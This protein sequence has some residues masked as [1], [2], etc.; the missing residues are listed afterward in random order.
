MSVHKARYF[1]GRSSQSECPML[2]S[3][4]AEPQEGHSLPQGPPVHVV[5]QGPQLHQSC[6]GCV[7]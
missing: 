7:H 2:G 6:T 4:G 1:R 3:E 5:Q